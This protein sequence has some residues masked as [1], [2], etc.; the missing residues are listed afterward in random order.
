MTETPAAPA[1]TCP[2]CGA[3]LET[4]A[5]FCE[6]C[7]KAVGPETPAAAPVA[8]GEPSPLD[9]VSPISAVTPGV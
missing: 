4:D 1:Q 7:G 2:H 5:K 9:D 8:A 6:A 3:F